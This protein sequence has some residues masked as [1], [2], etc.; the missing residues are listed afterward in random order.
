MATIK[1]VSE[2]AKVSVATVSR[3]VNGSAWVA[4]ATQQRVKDAMAQL[5]CQPNITA[6]TCAL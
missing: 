2:L 5:S 4:E 1:Q 6:E 3:V